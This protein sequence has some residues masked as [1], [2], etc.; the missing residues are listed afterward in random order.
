V[1]EAQILFEQKGGIGLV[2]LNRPKAMN[3]LNLEMYREFDPY[4]DRWDAD[5]DVH[6]I[7]IRGAGGR[8][9]CAGGDVVALW[10][11]GQGIKSPDDPKR[12]FF[13]EEYRLIRKI[14]RLSKP[15][16]ALMNGITMGGGVGVSVNGAYRVATES[17]MLAMPENGIGLI[18]DVGGTRF[19]GNC[20][21]HLGLYLGLTGA[22]IRASALLYAGLATHFVVNEK[23]DA[24]IDALAGHAWDGRNRNAQA[25][26]ILAGFKGDPGPMP[27]EANLA[28]IERC[29]SGDGLDQIVARLGQTGSDWAKDALSAIQKA[30]PTSLQ[31][32]FRQLT[33]PAASI[34]AALEL[35]FRLVNYVMN[36][37]DFFEGVRALLV[38]K[39][40]SPRWHPASLDEVDVTPIDALFKTANANEMNFDSIVTEPMT[41]T[42]GRT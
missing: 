5:P 11:S 36:Q 23:L 34:E 14:H 7:V 18:P 12:V 6:A 31:I 24:L 39:D 2:T 22:R 27:L 42:G 21:G 32:A 41:R 9:F 19:L 35:E 13:Y 28:D 25:D 17:T 37:P 4:L 16:I 40:Q 26:S 3:T 33:T 10:Q 1:S 20:P 38:D 15:Y 29:F 30:S 8:A